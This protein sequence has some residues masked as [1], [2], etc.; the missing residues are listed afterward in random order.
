MALQI[1]PYDFADVVVAAPSKIKNITGS[2][3]FAPAGTTS[4]TLGTR[5][6]EI[7]LFVGTIALR[8]P[9]IVDITPYAWNAS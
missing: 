8:G 9:G 6:K 7:T 4:E 2:V 5:L 3:Y 1:I